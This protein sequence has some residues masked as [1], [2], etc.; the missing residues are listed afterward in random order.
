MSGSPGSG[1]ISLASVVGSNS[2][3]ASLDKRTTTGNFAPETG[4]QWELS[5]AASSA[6]GRLILVRR[7]ESDVFRPERRSRGLTRSPALRLL[8]T[9]FERLA[10]NLDFKPA[11]EL[12]TI[13]LNWAAF[14]GIRFQPFL[15]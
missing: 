1:P 8:Y 6:V 2:H 12:C 7:R 5:G 15:R 11:P 10:L 13:Q 4:L 3:E 9:V 14:A